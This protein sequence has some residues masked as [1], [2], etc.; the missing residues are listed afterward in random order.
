MKLIRSTIGTTGILLVLA[1]LVPAALAAEVVATSQQVLTQA[2]E[3]DPSVPRL[4]NDAGG[5]A[6]FDL[7][8][9]GP[10]QTVERCIR[11]H[12]GDAPS[13]EIELLLRGDVGG[14][15][16]AEYLDLIVEVGAG[17]HFGDCDGFT[18]RAQAFA[19]SLAGFGALTHDSGVR[20]PL[21]ESGAL[22]YR[23]TVTLRPDPGAQGK[24]ASLDLAWEAR[25]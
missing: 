4:G 24:T 8:A 17:G 18:P 22:T 5:R 11:I 15:G 7:P 10:G 1:L 19:G 23:F 20:S 2:P 13:G 25:G 6:L 12:L 3:T 16:L 21:P 14:T 9:M